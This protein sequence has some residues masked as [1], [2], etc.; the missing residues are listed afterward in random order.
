MSQEAYGRSLAL[1]AHSCQGYRMKVSAL[2]ES[3]F[4]PCPPPLYAHKSYVI[5]RTPGESSYFCKGDPEGTMPGHLPS[6]TKICPSQAMW[7][8]LDLARLLEGWQPLQLPTRAKNKAHRTLAAVV[9]VV[10]L[11]STA[12]HPSLLANGKPIDAD[13]AKLS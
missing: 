9:A 2:R 8:P 7:Q 1:C 5:V 4:V 13:V 6:K 11:A 12:T 3:A 10:G